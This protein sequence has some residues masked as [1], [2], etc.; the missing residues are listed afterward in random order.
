MTSNKGLSPTFCAFPWMHLH[1]W[2]EGKAML[3]CVAHGGE[4]G[5][6]VGDFSKNTFVEIMNNEKMK[7]IRLK[8]LAGEKPEQCTACWENEDVHGRPSFRENTLTTYA[9]DIPILLE[10]TNPDGSITDPVMYYMDFR[11]SNLCNLGCKTC[12][13]PLSS[14][15][16]NWR[17]DKNE[18]RF[19]K[20]KNVL[21]DRGTITSFVYARPDFLDVD[22]FP[23]IKDVRGFYFAGGE[24]LMHPEHYEILKYLDENKMY[25][26]YIIYS[27]NM[28]TLKWKSVDFPE[29]WKN[30]KNIQFVCSIDGYQEGLEYIR[31]NSKNAVVYGNLQKLI[32]FKRANPDKMFSVSIC[33]THSIY[34]AYYTREF[35][36]YLD[37]LGLLDHFT[38]LDNIM[39]N[40][41][42]GDINSPS[43][44]PDFAKEELKQKRIADLESPVMQKVFSRFPPLRNDFN[45]I[46]EILTHT[47]EFTFDKFIKHANRDPGK[48]IETS[49]PWLASVFERYK[50]Q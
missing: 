37:S 9:S 40:Y 21:S 17:A 48:S 24:P 3:C 46:H 23:Y 11:F 41:S 18:L 19:L 5:G 7:S 13:S 28:T 36:E 4:N 38:G 26:K 44:L 27:T 43:I 15:L 6:E 50:N 32:E 39:L 16:A 34:N 10:K 25:D 2:P 45:Q 14:T 49:L 31:N 8:M 1:A 22:V 29:I 33:Y 12:G 30:F 42:F 20:D 35:F 47:P